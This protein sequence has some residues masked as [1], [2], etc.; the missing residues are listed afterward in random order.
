MSASTSIWSD[1]RNEFQREDNMVY[2]II[3]ANVIVFLAIN[4]V[5]VGIFFVLGQEGI[6][7]FPGNNLFTDIVRWFSVP[8]ALGDVISKPWTLFTYMFLQEGIFHILFNMLMLFWFGTILRDMSGNHRILPVY[9]LG[10]LSGAILYI[11]AFNLAPVF[12]PHLEG[13]FAL[14]ASA[15]V[16]AVVVAAAALAPEYRLHLI[17]FGPV[18]IKFIALVLV[19]LDVILLP[20]GNYGGHLAHLGGAIFGFVFVKQ[21]QRGVDMSSW[22]SSATGALLGLFTKS[23]GKMKAHRGGAQKRRSQASEQ[24]KIDVI[25]DKISQS[26]YDS[27]STEEKEFL[28]KAS[29]DKE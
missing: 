10:G 13:S 29:K 21:L 2:R 24:E 6:N 12:Q 3:V 8:A 15:G 25:L 18:R 19:I 4:L 5:R 28:F 1:I 23:E 7:P 14:G 17:L 16:L 20:G 27:L 22:F 26:G 9:I 11:I